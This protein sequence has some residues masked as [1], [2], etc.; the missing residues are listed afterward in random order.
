MGRKQYEATFKAK[1]A[2]E[3]IK[4]SAG[5]VAYDPRR[6]PTCRQALKARGMKRTALCI[7]DAHAGIQAAVRKEWLGASWQPFLL[8]APNL[9]QISRD[10]G[11]G[12]LIVEQK[13]REI[14]KIAQRVYVLRNGSVS[15]SGSAESLQDEKKLRDV[16][17]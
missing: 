4:A 16:N 7:S 10:S 2:L 13:V 1:V 14:V 11:A 15:F 12:V 8:P 5:R 9:S 6:S 3:A 17:L